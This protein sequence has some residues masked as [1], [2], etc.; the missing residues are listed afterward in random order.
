[1]YIS[2]MVNP[3]PMVNMVMESYLETIYWKSN[4]DTFDPLKLPLGGPEPTLL[5]VHL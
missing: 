3:K 5:G 4:E 1:M 2:S